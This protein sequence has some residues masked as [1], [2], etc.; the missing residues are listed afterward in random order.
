MFTGRIEEIGEIES[1]IDQ[2]IVV[3]AHPGARAGSG[4]A[5]R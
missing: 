4:P 2:R 3:R 5:G 1:V